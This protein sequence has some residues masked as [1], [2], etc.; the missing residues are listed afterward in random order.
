MRILL[1]TLTMGGVLLLGGCVAIPETNDDLAALEA[2]LQQ[3]ENANEVQR[4]AALELDAAADE[5]AEARAAWAE[6]GDSAEYRH[7]LYVA[8]RNLD[9][10]ETKAQVAVTE[11]SAEQLRDRRR[12]L[13]LEARASRAERGREAAEARAEG[14]MTAAE[15]ARLEAAQASAQA[16]SAREAAVLAESQREAAEARAEAA[17][18]RTAELIVR[19]EELEA[20][21]TD[22]GTVL[23]LAGV[24]F[25]VDR[26]E[27]KPGGERQVDKIADFLNDNPERQI[28]V[29]GFTDSTGSDSY[30]QQLSER[31]ANAVRRHLID[32]G[33]GAERIVVVGYGEQYP[34]T[35]N[36]SAAGRQQNRRVEV[37]ISDDDQPVRERRA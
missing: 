28:R 7:K 17:E 37:I 1:T 11:A 30:N 22:R 18:Q 8:Q 16:E 9:I 13:R 33:V 15:L 4:Y 27:L 10:A 31:R 34:V 20:I 3:A 21:K 29:E 19:L 23:T 12:A 25:D 6:H 35:S 2:R 32:Q 24:L 14:A 5:V 36:D 26:A